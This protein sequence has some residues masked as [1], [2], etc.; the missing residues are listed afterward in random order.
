LKQGNPHGNHGPI[1]IA[2]GAKDLRSR[3]HSR[4]RGWRRRWREPSG[5]PWC[6]LGLF[7]C[8]L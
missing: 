3:H 1:R 5:W 7:A 6:P 2:S 8:H 4:R